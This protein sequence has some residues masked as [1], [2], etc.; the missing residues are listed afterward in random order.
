M[1]YEGEW[2][3]DKKKGEG[4]LRYE[5]GRKIKGRWESNNRYI[6]II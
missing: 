3:D 6:P 4:I 1:L 5:D 2:E